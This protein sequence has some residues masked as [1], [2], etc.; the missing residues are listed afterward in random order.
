MQTTICLKSEA[1]IPANW[2]A[3]EEYD[4]SFLRPV[5]KEEYPDLDWDMYFPQFITF[6]KLLT[7]QSK[8]RLP[9]QG[10]DRLLHVFICHTRTYRDF[11]QTMY[12]HFVDHE[13]ETNLDRETV[14]IGHYA[15]Q[16][17]ALEFFEKDPFVYDY[18]GQDCQ[19][20]AGNC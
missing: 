10:V 6:L 2:K 12:G 7:V 5:A 9:S 3:I 1:V 19:C 4:F 20:E 11:C 18:K 16:A 13:P 14:K 8:L 17:L 15:L